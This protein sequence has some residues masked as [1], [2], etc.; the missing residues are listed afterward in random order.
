MVALISQERRLPPATVEQS[1]IVQQVLQ[2][3]VVDLVDLGL[4]GA[5]ARVCVHGP[6][7]R[8]VREQAD[9]LVAIA[10]ELAE[11]AADRAATLGSCPDGRAATVAERSSAERFPAGS[12]PDGDVAEAIAATLTAL[13]RQFRHRIAVTGAADPATR[14]LLID[15][16]ARLE[17]LRWMWHAQFARPT[18]V[19]SE[20]PRPG[21]AP[22]SRHDPATDPLPLAGVRS[23]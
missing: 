19:L 5:Q 2:A 11:T 10:R 16:T 8:A 17:H 6:D 21:G 23:A 7:M 4:I 12:H 3:C 22:H 20:R 9:E 1:R 15:T 13:V 14:R 18:R